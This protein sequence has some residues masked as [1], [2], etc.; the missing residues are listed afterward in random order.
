MLPRWSADGGELFFFDRYLGERG[1]MMVAR[2]AST[3][4]AWNEPVPLF[5]I[6]QAQDFAVAPNGRGI[7]FVAPNPDAEAHEVL[8]AVNWLQ[9]FLPR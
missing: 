7:Y 2:R 8:V 5:E 1:R 4:V 6:V 9:Q 3:G